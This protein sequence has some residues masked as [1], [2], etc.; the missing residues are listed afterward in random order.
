MTPMFSRRHPVCVS[1][2]LWLGKACCCYGLGTLSVASRGEIP[3]SHPGPVAVKQSPPRWETDRP[4]PQRRRGRR[5]APDW[6][7][8]TS[9]RW[10]RSGGTGTPTTTEGG[11]V[12]ASGERTLTRTTNPSGIHPAEL[13]MYLLYWGTDW[14]GCRTGNGE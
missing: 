9:T 14:I 5:V 3:W 11:A 2:F 7:A 6:T 13:S 8:T 4:L 1:F 12:P 10:R